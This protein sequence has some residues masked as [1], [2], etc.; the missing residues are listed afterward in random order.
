M[1]SLYHKL[2]IKMALGN[3]EAESSFQK[4]VRS[5]IYSGF[6]FNYSMCLMDT[7]HLCWIL[8][9]Y[10]LCHKASWRIWEHEFNVY[11]ITAWFWSWGILSDHFSWSFPSR[12][13]YSTYQLKFFLLCRCFHSIKFCCTMHFL[14]CMGQ[15]QF[16]E[17]ETGSP[18]FVKYEFKEEGTQE[19][20]GSSCTD[21]KQVKG[22]SLS[23]W[24][25]ALGQTKRKAD[26][27]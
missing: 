20:L 16:W 9:T 3:L 26:V 18:I 19:S 7:S 6:S 5:S 11:L 8:I 23:Y 24:S 22:S 17:R 15:S 21:I 25:H 13:I 14:V 4:L 12:E 1:C 2:Q 10:P 27:R